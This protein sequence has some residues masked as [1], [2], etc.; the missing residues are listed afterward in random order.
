MLGK[1]AARSLILFLLS[2]TVGVACEAEVGE[3]QPEVQQ[4]FDTASPSRVELQPGT[5]DNGAGRS[6]SVMLE[7]YPN[8]V[9]GIVRS[10]TGSSETSGPLEP[11][12]TQAPGFPDV[13]LPDPPVDYATVYE[14]EVTSVVV[15]SS[16][17]PGETLTL[18][19]GGAVIEGT[20]YFYRD[21]PLM[22]VGEEYLFFLKPEDDLVR[23]MGPFSRFRLDSAERLVPVAEKSAV[24]PAVMELTCL[25]LTEATPLIVAAAA[26]SPSLYGAPSTPTWNPRLACD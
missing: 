3:E 26:E 24:L 16:L 7:R 8:A 5:L 1:L 23:R 25:S 15:S 6:L 22:R 18:L 9:V 13:A 21:D 10:A 14:V 4:A 20:E 11:L 12:F 2:G 17:T 19:T